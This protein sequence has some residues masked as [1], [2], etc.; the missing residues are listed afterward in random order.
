MTPRPE[1]L[2]LSGLR[3]TNFDS[4]TNT[5][6]AIN[7]K[8]KIARIVGTTTVSTNRIFE[9]LKGLR[10]RI[11]TR[12]KGSLRA[13]PLSAPGGDGSILSNLA[14]MFHLC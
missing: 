12:S 13:V 14:I 7:P 9:R 6:D 10:S 1:L 3:T 8:Y 2:G 11:S 5:S 4:D